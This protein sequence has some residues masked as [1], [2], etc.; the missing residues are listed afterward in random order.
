MF[1]L[2]QRQMHNLFWYSTGRVHDNAIRIPRE[3][4]VAN[5]P[6]AHRAD[7]RA[8]I[9]K[10]GIAHIHILL[11]HV[12]P[13]HLRQLSQH[14]R[15]P[16]LLVQLRQIHLNALHNLCVKAADHNHILQRQRVWKEVN[17]HNGIHLATNH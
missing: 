6:L 4:R 10:R 13:S 16:S 5:H 7:C 3:H 15:A 1:V 12:Q 2:E 8:G 11:A 9:L 17:H 14:Q